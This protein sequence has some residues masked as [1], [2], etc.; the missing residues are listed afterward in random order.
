VVVVE[1]LSSET[2]FVEK[3]AA[4]SKKKFSIIVI[5]FHS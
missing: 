3:L 4:F 2:K 1:L 5:I